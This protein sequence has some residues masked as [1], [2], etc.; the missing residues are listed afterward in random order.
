[1]PRLLRRPSDGERFLQFED[2]SYR[3][4]TDADMGLLGEVTVTQEMPQGFLTTRLQ[5]KN[6]AS[7]PGAAKAWLRQIGYYVADMDDRGGFNFAVQKSQFDEN[8]NIKPADPTAWKVVDPKGFSSP[9]EFFFDMLDLTTDVVEGILTGMATVAAATATAPSGP[10]ALAAGVAAGGAT[11][12]GLTGIRQIVGKAM[13][14]P[15]NIDPVQVALIGGLS[16]VAP[17]A[18]AALSKVFRPMI[19]MAVRNLKDSAG[20]PTALA[21]RL[22]GLGDFEGADAAKDIFTRATRFGTPGH[23]LHRPADVLKQ[24]QSQIDSIQ[25]SGFTELKELS[26]MI[27]RNADEAVDIAPAI[28]KITD[29]KLDRAA[30]GE[31]RDLANAFLD[32]LGG[33]IPPNGIN[34]RLT[35]LDG[36][37][38]A[39]A[40]KGSIKVSPETADFFTK[41]LQDAAAEKGAFTGKQIAIT[42][43]IPQQFTTALADAAR[44][45]R[46]ALE[47]VMD[48]AVGRV[49]Y[50]NSVGD[51][52][53]QLPNQSGQLSPVTFSNLRL[54]VAE[55]TRVK[56]EISKIFGRGAGEAG[57]SNLNTLFG[58][59]KEGRRS[60]LADFD[61]LFHTTHVQNATAG[62]EL[63]LS[64]A[65]ADTFAARQF[66][67]AGA[68][69][70][71]F[72]QIGGFTATGQFLGF[73]IGSS[74]GAKL[75][76]AEG[77]GTG[78]LLGLGLASPRLLVFAGRQA[79]RLKPLTR[80][81]SFT[82]DKLGEM[83]S[84]AP[85]F[86]E[87]VR[88]NLLAREVSKQIIPTDRP[89][90]R[91]DHQK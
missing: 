59:S 36:G 35:R 64:E 66:R 78:G 34:L 52:V 80:P 54:R 37:R 68:A 41:S 2:G 38:F 86:G 58:T 15:E 90:M 84:R 50:V 24:I 70:G 57:E 21:S 43:K 26:T 51:L 10:G 61:R 7:N 42:S 49:S 20:I 32:D 87:R 88:F 39:T 44:T 29:I 30:A 8:G 53:T 19:R 81:I 31:A 25:N 79:G 14:I 75:G 91:Q 5:L 6:F 16:A 45:S 13:G 63:G 47:K 18:T 46:L 40:G 65:A 23:S 22:A 60:V 74:I 69:F 76:G 33:K 72:P 83:A 28:R 9:K 4:V 73:A 56:S 55:M 3:P 62:F 11:G 1:M 48:K 82:L 67:G 17:V 12:A 71:E 27:L 85:T 89:V 77:A